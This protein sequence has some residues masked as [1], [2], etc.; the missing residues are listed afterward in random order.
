MN[1]DHVVSLYFQTP[2]PLSSACCFGCILQSSEGQ[3][4]C[5]NASATIIYNTVVFL[6]FSVGLQRHTHFLL[7]S[8]LYHRT[9]YF[10]LKADRMTAF[11]TFKEICKFPGVWFGPLATH[12]LAMKTNLDTHGSFFSLTSDCEVI[13]PPLLPQDANK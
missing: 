13:I 9:K 5:F 7:S 3:Q 6:S 12:D 2:L 4:T 1:V 8:V 10:I 11:E